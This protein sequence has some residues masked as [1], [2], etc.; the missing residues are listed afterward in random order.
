MSDM[1]NSYICYGTVGLR[2]AA[3]SFAHSEM[4][5]RECSCG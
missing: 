2:G 1:S 4:S 3:V 5:S